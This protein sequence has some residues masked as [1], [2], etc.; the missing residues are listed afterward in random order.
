M[1]KHGITCPPSE[2]EQKAG[3][4]FKVNHKGRYEW[5]A[6][7]ERFLFFFNRWIASKKKFRV[8]ID[9]DP[10][11]TMLVRF[12]LSNQAESE[13]LESLKPS[14][15]IKTVACKCESGN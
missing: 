7:I 4:Q 5:F 1:E 2:D 8:T 13:I 11:W 9:F 6:A 14:Q 15:E 12:R 10:E 3:E